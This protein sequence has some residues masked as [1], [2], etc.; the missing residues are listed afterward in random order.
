MYDLIVLG[1]GP[2]GYLGAERAGHAGLNVL[3]IESRA[4][5]GVCL[6]EGC[7]PSKTLLYSAKVFDNARHGE[8]FGVHTSDI[9]LNHGEVISRKNRVVKT[10]T[11]GVRKTLTDC[12][13]TIVQ[14]TG[15]IAGREPDGS[16]RVTVNGETHTGRRLLIATGS[17]PILPPIPGLAD[18]LKSGVAMTNREILDLTS[19]PEK[20]VIVGGGVIGLEMAGY[21]AAAGAKVTVVEML[22]A[23]G[24]P[25]DSDIA[26]VLQ[27]DLAAKGI[28]FELNAKVVSIGEKVVFERGGQ[29]TVIPADKVLVSIGRRPVVTGFG[30]ENTGLDAN[31]RRIQTD[32]HMRAGAPNVYAAG[33]VTGEVMLAHVAYRQAEAAVNHMLGKRDA[34][35]YDVIPSVIYTSPEAAAVGETE[36]GARDKGL[37]IDTVKLPMNFSGRYLAE[38]Q[39]GDGICKLIDDANNRR[40][41]GCHIIGSYASEIIMSAAV[42][43]D[44]CMTVERAKTMIFPHPTVGEIIREALFS[45]K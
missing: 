32:R 44:A 40:I 25:I 4:I 19:V 15:Y 33:D 45:F 28:T 14:G 6:N 27:K 20:L 34:M 11:A 37:E 41:L 36:Q 23:I 12:G 24:G 17:E 22:G 2:A 8:A 31:A 30:L 16:L 13:V 21:Y 3:L 10:L 29:Q 1:G 42:M 5:G 38:N 9:T 39:K 26:T 35:R 7:I 43:I 18:S